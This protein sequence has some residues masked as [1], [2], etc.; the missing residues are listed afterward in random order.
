MPDR[1]GGMKYLLEATDPAISWVEACAARKPNSETW[2]KFLYEEVY[3]WFGC[4]LLCLVDGGS[5]FKGAVDILFKQYGIVVIVSSPYHPEGNGHAERSHQTLVKFD[6]SSLWKGHFPLATLGA[7]RAL[8]NEMLNFSND[9]LYSLFL[10]LR[11]T[12]PFRF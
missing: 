7:C 8:G 6:S 11:L 9:G 4:V 12:S 3:S 5:E 2:A 10:A 1:F